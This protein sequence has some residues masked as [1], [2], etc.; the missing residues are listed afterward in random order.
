MNVYFGIVKV[1]DDVLI[2]YNVYGLNVDFGNWFVKD[3]GIIVCF[4]DLLIGVGIVE[5]I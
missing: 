2:L 1:G 4:Y 5:L 3:F